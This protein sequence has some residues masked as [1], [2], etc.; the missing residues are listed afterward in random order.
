MAHVML[1][2]TYFNILFTDSRLFNLIFIYIKLTQFLLKSKLNSNNRNFA[3]FPAAKFLS[4]YSCTMLCMQL[5]QFCI[6][7]AS[8]RIKIEYMNNL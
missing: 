1:Y 4:K 2:L 8:I 5:L 7:I 6:F 3:V